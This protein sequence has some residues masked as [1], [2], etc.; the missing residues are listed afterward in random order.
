MPKLVL[1]ALL[2]VSG[3]AD[4]LEP[5]NLRHYMFT[6][7]ISGNLNALKPSKLKRSGSKRFAT[8]VYEISMVRTKHQFLP[9]QFPPTTIFA[10]ADRNKKGFFPGPAIVAMKDTPIEIIWTN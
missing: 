1:C 3:F 9:D 7:E 4:L 10:Y 6:E 5:E 8:E 2:F